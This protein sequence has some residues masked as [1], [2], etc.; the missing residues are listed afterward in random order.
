MNRDQVTTT[1]TEQLQ[2]PRPNV[3][4]LPF[5]PNFQSPQGMLYRMHPMMMQQQQQQYLSVQNLQST[6]SGSP[7]PQP[8]PGA[9][10][11]LPASSSLNQSL[12]FNSTQIN[13]GISGSQLPYSATFPNM[14]T[15]NLDG[16]LT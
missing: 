11:H 7:S 1:G 3:P 5:H 16:S 8:S 15:S 9:G 4:L 6:K 14:S 10:I 12:S 2:P 13:N